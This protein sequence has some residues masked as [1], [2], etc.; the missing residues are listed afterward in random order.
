LINSINNLSNDSQNKS[1]FKLKEFIFTLEK[2]GKRMKRGFEPHS[3][4]YK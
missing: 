3:V 1:V 2:S 4:E